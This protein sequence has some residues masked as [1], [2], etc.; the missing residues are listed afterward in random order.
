M[1]ESFLEEDLGQVEIRK[2]FQRKAGNKDEV[3]VIFQSKDIRDAVKTKAHCL[4]NF[5]GEAGMLLDIPDHLQKAFKAFMALAFDLKK[6]FPELKRSVKFDEDDLSLF[7]D[8]QTATEA[9]WKRVHPEQA[10]KATA[11]RRREGSGPQ[12]LDSDVLLGMLDAE[13]GQNDQ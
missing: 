9:Q 5:Q 12:S 1:E 4:A 10:R 7:M 3:C 11:S 2:I 13:D 8:F 6:K